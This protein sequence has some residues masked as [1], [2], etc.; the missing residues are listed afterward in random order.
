MFG[1]H[2]AGPDEAMLVSSRR[3]RRRGVPFRVITG[4]GGFG[5]PLGRR[6]WRVPLGV[7]EVEV[8]ESCLSNQGIALLVRAVIT[9]RVGDDEQSVLAAARRFAGDPEAMRLAAERV[10]AECVQQA[11]TARTVEE[12]VT[13]RNGWAGEVGE[14]ARVGL[15]AMG[16]AAEAVLMPA[17]EDSPPD[18]GCLA[19][20]AAVHHAAIGRAAAEAEETSHRSQAE[21]HRDTQLARAR[22]QGE[23]ATAEAEATQAGPLAQARAQGE[24]ITAQLELAGQSAEPAGRPAD[25]GTRETGPGPGPVGTADEG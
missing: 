16:L 14:A 8:A 21:Y 22:Y 1:Y 19:A 24:V 10:G 12:V 20:M 6:V 4:R 3:S 23:V 5:P 9:F 25:Q 7:C 13:D 17:V 15:A 2:V 18:S 11:I